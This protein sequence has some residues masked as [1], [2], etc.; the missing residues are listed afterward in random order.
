[1][2]QITLEEATVLDMLEE[3]DRR[4]VC[5]VYQ[6]V[7]CPNRPTDAFHLIRGEA[8]TDDLAGWMCSAAVCT[9]DKAIDNE[10]EHI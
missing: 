9:I 6:Q 3:L 7:P 4:G 2:N 1:M 8:I 5:F 10:W